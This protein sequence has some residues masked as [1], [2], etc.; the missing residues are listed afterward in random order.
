M[1]TVYLDTTKGDEEAMGRGVRGSEV[2]SEEL[3]E[4]SEKIMGHDR[5]KVW[6]S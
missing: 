4:R 2:S 5:V 1:T 3:K 6:A